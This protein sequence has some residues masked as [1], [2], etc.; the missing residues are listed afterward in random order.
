M[1]EKTAESKRKKPKV[2]GRQKGTPN[3]LSST[4]KENII[5]VFNRLD[6]T[7]GMARWAQRNR[8]EFY[9]IYARLLPTELTTDPNAPLT[10]IF[11]DPTQRPDGYDRKP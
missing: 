4:A 1:E 11:R 3:K 9:K 2:G 8:T 10:V 5:A 6:G 7:A